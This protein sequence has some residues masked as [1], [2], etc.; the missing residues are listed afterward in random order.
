MRSNEA[1]LATELK[2][3][4]GITSTKR[5]AR[6]GITKRSVEA[7]VRQGR[8]V[9]AG[10]GVLA[11]AS[12]PVDLDHRMALACAVTGGVVMFP[13]AGVVWQLRKTPRD[14][15]VHV[16]VPMDRRV[17]QPPGVRV[18]RT[19]SL[20]ETHVVRRADGIDITSPPL[21]AIDAA[22]VLAADDLES[23][24]EH[25]IDLGYF[26]IATL[27][28]LAEPRC[29]KGRR[30]STRLSAVLRSRG[31]AGRPVRSDHELR[32]ERAMRRRGF[33]ALVREHRLVLSSGEVIH[34]DLGIPE[35]RFFV[36]VDH[37]TWHGRRRQSSYDRARDL[38]ARADGY[39]VER[40][41]DLA[42]DE[43]LDA[44]IED[45]WRVWQG[46][47][48]SERH[49]TGAADSAESANSPPGPTSLHR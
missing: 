17:A 19:R 5:L 39:H 22:A 32:L 43:D 48:R 14:S 31:T 16:C 24:I 30:G 38:R 11:S 25:G 4:H 35:D 7:L 6:L 1:A 46:I 29:G 36:E 40:V 34:P 3:R 47:L 18:H 15:D 26:T 33:P 8:L 23:L 44:T 42:L 21:T 12:W 13:T 10:N 28:H 37:M 9:R 2:R 41:S 49:P 27:R 45:L 20:P